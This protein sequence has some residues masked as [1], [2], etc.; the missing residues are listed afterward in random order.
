MGLV[1]WPLGSGSSCYCALGARALGSYSQWL[2]LDAWALGLESDGFRVSGVEGGTLGARGELNA[3]SSSY[4]CSSPSAELSKAEKE[5]EAD[6]EL[7]RNGL[8]R[9][10]SLR[11]S[12]PPSGPKEAEPFPSL[13]RNS[14]G[15]PVACG[16]RAQDRPP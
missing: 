4:S 16:N 5:G 7:K 11:S 12:V 8:G 15:D 13:A 10:M 9:P 1:T 14:G 6:Q 3:Y 2:D